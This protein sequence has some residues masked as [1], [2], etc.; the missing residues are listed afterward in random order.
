[1][2]VVTTCEKVN[3]QKNEKMKLQAAKNRMTP[4][5]FEPPPIKTAT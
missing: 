1:M 4:G 3:E 5:G 2:L